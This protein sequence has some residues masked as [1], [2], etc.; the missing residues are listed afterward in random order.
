[1]FNYMEM[2]GS[3][4]CSLA[5][6]CC[7]CIDRP[8]EIT[9]VPGRSLF[10]YFKLVIGFLTLSKVQFVRQDERSGNRLVEF[11]IRKNES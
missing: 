10:E 5:D 6:Q 11:V 9:S 2:S 4:F 1:M 7:I 3:V 8:Q